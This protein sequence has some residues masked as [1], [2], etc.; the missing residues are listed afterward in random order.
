VRGWMGPR[1]GVSLGFG[2]LRSI[3]IVAIIAVAVPLAVHPALGAEGD[4]SSTWDYRTIYVVWDEQTFDWRAD[5]T[6]G[7]STAG[8]EAVL[9]NEG[10]DGWELVELAHERFDPVVNGETTSQEARRLRLV[11]KRPAVAAAAAAPFVAISGF[12]FQPASLDVSAGS[13]VSW[14]N[15]D[16]APHTVT[17]SDGAF[18]SGSLSSGGTFDFTFAEAGTYAYACA[19]HPSMTGSIVVS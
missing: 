15:Q 6:D 17:A 3:V 14:E 5:W 8:L 4:E 10:D 9:D 1:G 11:L 18:D 7:T 12:S 19:I 2:W 13:T 16:G